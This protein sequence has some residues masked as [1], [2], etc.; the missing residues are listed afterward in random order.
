V[1][2]EVR[3]GP[4]AVTIIQAAGSLQGPLIVM[5]SHGRGGLGR[6]VYGSVADAVLRESHI[7]VLLVRPPAVS[8]RR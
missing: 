8:S 4:A 7:P 6:L 3:E 2:T 5:S 1:D